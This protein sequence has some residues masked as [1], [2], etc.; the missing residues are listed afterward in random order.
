M[1]L[2]AVGDSTLYGFSDLSARAFD[3]LTLVDAAVASAR[4][5]LI[6]PPWVVAH[7][8]TGLWNFVDGGYA[9]NSGSTTALE[10]YKALEPTAAMLNA[11]LYLII[12]TDAVAAP[13]PLKINGSGF[14]DTMAPISALLNVR[15]QLASRAVTQAIDHFKPREPKELVARSGDSKLLIARLEQRSVPL[16]L[17]W[18][19]SQTEIDFVQLILGKPECREAAEANEPSK[20]SRG[21]ATASDIEATTQTIIDNS[22]IKKRIIDVL[23]RPPP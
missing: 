3:N 21:P 19:I 13:D 9:D 2:K 23:S 22:C 17:G 16:T 1:P 5:P 18:K 20:I 11:D 6:A 10:I 15:A 7:G 12:L 14:S 8:G 4:F